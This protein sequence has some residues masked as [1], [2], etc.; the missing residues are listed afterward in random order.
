MGRCRY[1][2]SV[3]VFRYTG[4]Y[5]FKSVRYLSSVFLKYR[6]IGSVFSVFTLRASY[7]RRSIVI[8]SVCGGWVAG[9]V[10]NLFVCLWVCYHDNSKL[11]ASILT[12]LGL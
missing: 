9:W 5:F 7:L 4:R 12:K 11:H 2:K 3:S 10:C 1:F 6:D 8:G